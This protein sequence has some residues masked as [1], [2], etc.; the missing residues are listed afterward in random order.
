MPPKHHR[1]RGKKNSDNRNRRNK[2][3]GR[4]QQY[5]QFN[6]QRGYGYNNNNQKNNMPMYPGMMYPRGMQGMQG[7]QGR[8][9]MYPGFMPYNPG[10]FP[11]QGSMG[12]YPNPRFNP[13]MKPNQGFPGYTGPD[14]KKK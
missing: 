11:N 7:M 3:E 6:S 10:M 13:Y 4:R 12:F 8:Q 2:A 14:D 5:G 1:R 9:G